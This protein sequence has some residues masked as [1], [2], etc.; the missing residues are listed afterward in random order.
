MGSVELVL[1][2]CPVC[3]GEAPEVGVC[4]RC[5][6]AG[7]FDQDGEP[8]YPPA[9]FDGW[10]P[11]KLVELSTS[12]RE[13][14]DAGVPV[15]PTMSELRR[16]H[17]MSKHTPPDGA[18]TPAR[19]LTL[20]NVVE[21]AFATLNRTG[22]DHSTVR[23][24]R[25]AKGDTQIEVSVRTGEQGIDTVEQA[26]AKARAVYDELARDYPMP[27]EAPAPLP[28]PKPKPAAAIAPKPAG[29]RKS[30]AGS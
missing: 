30:R 11:R 29:R 26:A 12:T 18:A 14:R 27:P 7:C 13:R 20:S 24:A 5:R 9:P 23:L 3:V 22:Q 6:G 19:R 25:N 8:F 15:A 16:L 10:T 4:P 1:T 2:L 17:A 28:P 21:L